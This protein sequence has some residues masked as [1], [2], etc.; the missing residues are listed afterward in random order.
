MSRI[1]SDRPPE[2]PY[3]LSRTPTDLLAHFPL[4]E[5]GAYRSIGS[6]QWDPETGEFLLTEARPYQAGRVFYAIPLPTERFRAEFEV[7]MDRGSGL[8]AG[9]DGMTFAFTRTYRYP[10]VRGNSL[11]FGGVGYAVEFD[12]FRSHT[13]G[14]DPLG[15]HIAVLEGDADKSLHPSVIKGRLN[16][17]DWHRLAVDFASGRITVTYDGE[18]VISR[19]TITGY[20]PFTGYFGF[21]AA[22]GSGYQRHRVRNFRLEIPA[23]E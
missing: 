17:G 11:D 20:E 13:W 9:A 3:H 5:T 4:N 16:D 6:A 8:E 18:D 19:Y 23:A 14:K 1:V 21:T 7:C 12:C 2:R 15:H 10:T 22:T